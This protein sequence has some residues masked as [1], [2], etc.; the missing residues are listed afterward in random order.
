MVVVRIV[1]MASQTVEVDSVTEEEW[2]V[3]SFKAEAVESETLR[4]QVACLMI[5]AREVGQTEEEC[6]V[7]DRVVPTWQEME[8]SFAGTMTLMVVALSRTQSPEGEEA[9][10]FSTRDLTERKRTFT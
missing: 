4:C 2:V 10:S 8:A 3:H 6:E 1:L 5:T 9:S 7:E